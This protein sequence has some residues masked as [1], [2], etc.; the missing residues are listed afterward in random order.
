MNDTYTWK[1]ET[2]KIPTL[3]ETR[4][5]LDRESLDKNRSFLDRLYLKRRADEIRRAMK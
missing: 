5:F 1:G 2:F 3:E 4:K